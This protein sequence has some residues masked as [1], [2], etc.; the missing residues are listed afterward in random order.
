MHVLTMVFILILVMI[1]SLTFG[2]F[3]SHIETNH[4]RKKYKQIEVENVRLNDQIRSIKPDEVLR[5]E[6]EKFAYEAYQWKEKFEDFKYNANESIHKLDRKVDALME[7]NS[8][9]ITLLGKV[10][11]QAKLERRILANEIENT[12]GVAE[13]DDVDKLLATV[14]KEAKKYEV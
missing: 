1:T 11:A 6:R 4:W 7:K 10:V 12:M 9:L 2:Y 14:M 3:Y 13:S 5:K 8:N